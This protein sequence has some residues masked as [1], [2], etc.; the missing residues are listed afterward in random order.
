[1]GKSIRPTLA[2]I[3]NQEVKRALDME[4]PVI[5]A[6]GDVGGEESNY[7]EMYTMMEYTC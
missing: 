2:I 6:S 3:L 5:P 7:N 4:N 1:M